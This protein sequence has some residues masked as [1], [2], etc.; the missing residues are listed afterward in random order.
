MQ[1]KVVGGWR[2]Y[3]AGLP[4]S[5]A[6]NRRKN[7]LGGGTP[8]PFGQSRQKTLCYSRFRWATGRLNLIS[9][10]EFT[11]TLGSHHAKIEYLRA[12]IRVDID[13]RFGRASI[14]WVTTTRCTTNEISRRPSSLPP[15]RANPNK[16]RAPH[17]VLC[18]AQTWT[19][20][21]YLQRKIEQKPWE[22]SLRHGGCKNEKKYL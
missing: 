13:I 5:P 20:N 21:T 3:I 14:F 12:E 1:K 19:P 11:P 9:N 7:E 17:N 16:T 10:L 15:T 22:K 6:R 8:T 18:A 4:E 2:G